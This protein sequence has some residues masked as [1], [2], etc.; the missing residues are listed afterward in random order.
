[1]RWISFK[2]HWK[3]LGNNDRRIPIQTQAAAEFIWRLTSLRLGATFMSGLS[4][5]APAQ[6]VANY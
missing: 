5:A 6:N 3:K 4:G 2:E 1:M